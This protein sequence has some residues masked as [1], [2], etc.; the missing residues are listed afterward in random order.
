VAP[1]REDVK[2][3]INICS[4]TTDKVIILP[5]SYSLKYDRT[6]DSP[7]LAGKVKL[8]IKIASSAI[9]QI[10]KKQKRLDDSSSKILRCSSSKNISRASYSDDKSLKEPVTFI[11]CM[12][13]P[14][15]PLARVTRCSTKTKEGDKTNYCIHLESK[16]KKDSSH[17]IIQPVIDSKRMIL[18]Q[19][20]IF[21]HL[22]TWK[23]EE[24]QKQRF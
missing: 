3:R 6:D 21:I 16:L 14:K 17:K 23:F 4:R 5:K 20:H 15:G 8:P 9:L 7:A 22:K 12:T 1:R 19:F 11:E 10:D 2:Q 24:N 18:D 13:T